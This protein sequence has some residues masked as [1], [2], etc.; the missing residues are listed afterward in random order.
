MSRQVLTQTRVCVFCRM[1]AEPEQDEA[2]FVLHRAEHGHRSKL[3]IHHRTLDDRAH[4]HT[5]EFDSVPKE[6]TDEL[7]DLAK[8]LKLRCVRFIRLQASIW[9]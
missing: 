1:V 9:E 2:N 7:M 5:G 4:L 8:A 6:I 3:P